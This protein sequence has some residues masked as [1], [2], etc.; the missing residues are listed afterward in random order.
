MQRFFAI[1]AF[2]V[3][4]M[5]TLFAVISIVLLFYMYHKTFYPPVLKK[6]QSASKTPRILDSIDIILGYF[7]AYLFCATACLITLDAISE[8]D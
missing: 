3:P 5:V 6:N 7:A 8:G 2:I 1:V 4:N